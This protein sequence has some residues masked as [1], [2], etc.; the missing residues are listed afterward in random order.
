MT[1][2]KPESS[3]ITAESITEFCTL[4]T[5]GKLKVREGGGLARV[6]VIMLRL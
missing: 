6:S 1:K 4:F 2:Y 5:Q 3:A